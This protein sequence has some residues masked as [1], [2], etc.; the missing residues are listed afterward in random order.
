MS[1]IYF[2]NRQSGKTTM[3]IKHSAETNATIVVPNY[4]M[5][6]YIRLM[7]SDMKLDIPTPITVKKFIDQLSMG[8]LGKTDKYLIDELQM[9]LSVMNVDAATVDYNSV[10]VLRNQQKEGL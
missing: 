7:A 10:E 3:L 4:V 8:G 5:V 6:N 2:G 9:V 1:T